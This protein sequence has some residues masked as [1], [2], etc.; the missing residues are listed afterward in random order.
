MSPLRRK[1]DA[2]GGDAGDWERGRDIRLP[3]RVTL[4][5]GRELRCEKILRLLPGRRLVCRAGLGGET[6]LA[7]LFLGEEAEREA[8]ADADAVRAMMRGGI[9]TP[10][11]REEAKVRGRPHRALLF[12]YLPRARSFREAWTAGD[13]GTRQRLLDDLLRLV[14]RQHRAGLQQRDFHLGNF[15]LGAA[16]GLYAIDG[17]DLRVSPHPRGRTAAL[18]DLAML[19]GHL[20]RPELSRERLAAYFEE[21]GWPPDSGFEKRLRRAADHARHRRARRIGRKAFRNCSEFLVRRQGRFHLCQRRDLDP[22][23]LDAWMAAGGLAPRTGERLLK[24]GNSQ[25]V[26]QSRLGGRP[27]VVKRYN[28][29]NRQHALRRALSRSRASRSWE[30]AHRLRAY[31][32]ATPEPLAMIEERRGPFRGRAWLITAPA[33]GQGADRYLREA[34]DETDMVRLA[35]V[36]NAFADNQLAHGDMKASNFIMD[37]ARVQVID[38]DSMRRHRLPWRRR[39]AIHRDQAR[40]L[41]NWSGEQRQRFARLLHHCP[42]PS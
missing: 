23:V 24:E 13:A 9:P 38:L 12:D 33:P 36:V 18:A 1:R 40:F 22:S 34:L 25:T 35:E 28:L 42:R 14:A 15:I 27:V 2:S 5:D 11:L 17:G 31:H 10:A 41:E 8:R 4:E 32:I 3:F 16:G 26:W 20:P 29:K 30:N 7:K 39:A 37:E 6:F 19:F 21:R